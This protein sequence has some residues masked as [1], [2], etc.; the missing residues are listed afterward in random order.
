MLS[1]WRGVHLL[2]FLL[3]KVCLANCL[4]KDKY[5]LTMNKELFSKEP[6]LYKDKYILTMKKKMSKEL[7]NTQK[8][9]QQLNQ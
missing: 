5:I 9:R 4:Y 7:A 8:K 2:L 6:C 1:K 3:Q